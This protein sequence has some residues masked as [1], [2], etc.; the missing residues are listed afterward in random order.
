[1]KRKIDIHEIENMDKSRV[2]RIKK[3]NMIVSVF[4][5]HFKWQFFSVM[6]TEQIYSDIQNNWDILLTAHAV[7]CQNA[8]LTKFFLFAKSFILVV[9]VRIVDYQ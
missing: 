8:I 3:Q 1:M 6:V 7:S 4:H 5:Q 9:M 2:V